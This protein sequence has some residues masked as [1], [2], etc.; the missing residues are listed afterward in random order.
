MFGAYT[1]FR[2]S[3]KQERRRAA[4]RFSNFRDGEMESSMDLPRL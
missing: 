1:W 4:M 2:R 3:R